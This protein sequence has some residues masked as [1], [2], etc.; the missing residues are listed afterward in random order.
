MSRRQY[1]G[2]ESVPLP[3]APPPGPW[4]HIWYPGAPDAILGRGQRNR[5]AEIRFPGRSVNRGSTIRNREV[6]ENKVIF[7]RP[8]E[9]KKKIHSPD[10]IAH[11]SRVSSKAN[12]RH[13]AFK[14]KVIPDQES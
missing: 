4:H 12:T 9:K 5:T 11:A 7:L 13:R 10:F 8:K 6:I 2:E 3:A 1:K 14:G